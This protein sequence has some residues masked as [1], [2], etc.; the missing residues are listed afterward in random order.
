M[1]MHFVILLSVLGTSNRKFI[2]Y[3]P[4]KREN[5]E[6]G[7]NHKHWWKKGQS[8]GG[9]GIGILYAL[10]NS[11]LNNFVSFD[12]NYKVHIYIVNSDAV[13]YFYVWYH[14]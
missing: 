11:I 4:A 3:L 12:K 10:N 5:L 8:G 1:I 6:I 2:C 9:T 7:S 14:Y 13:Y